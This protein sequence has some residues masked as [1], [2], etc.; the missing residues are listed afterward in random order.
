MTKSH[1]YGISGY[2]HLDLPRAQF[3][4]ALAANGFHEIELAAKPGTF[5]DWLSDPA[6]ARREIEAA[7]LRVHSVHTPSTGWNNSSPDP[8]TRR[9]S[10]ESAASCLGP[11]A[12]VGAG[13][14]VWHPSVG[15]DYVPGTADIHRAN[16]IEAMAAFARK[17]AG[18]GLLTAVENLPRRGTDRPL[19]SVRELLPHVEQL[20]EKVGI[21]LDVGHSNANGLSP[22]DEALQAGLRIITMHMHDNDGKGEDQHR[23]PGNGTVD[24]PAYLRALETIGYRG[25][26][27]FEV[28]V[29]SL[30]EA[31][32]ALETIAGLVRRWNSL[33]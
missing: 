28:V 5:G 4:D 33:A 2:L 14:V 31:A 21:C 25:V 6:G 17:A 26:R 8:D 12:E 13:I 10:A 11:A 30:P 23:M 16:A 18:H 22:A 15:T 9:L 32:P 1:P 7:G 20:G 24:W 27:M 3:L 19:C 29:D